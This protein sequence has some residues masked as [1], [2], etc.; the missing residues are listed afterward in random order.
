MSALPCNYDQP[1]SATERSCK[2]C[3]GE[4]QGEMLKGEFVADDA[5]EDGKG[6]IHESCVLPEIVSTLSP[7]QRFE[8]LRFV[9]ALRIIQDASRFTLEL[10]D[11]HPLANFELRELSDAVDAQ[12]VLLDPDPSPFPEEL[13]FVRASAVV[14]AKAALFGE[15]GRVKGE[16]FMLDAA[17]C[18]VAYG[19]KTDR[20][21]FIKKAANR[22]CEA[23]HE[24]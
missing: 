8:M 16:I 5:R 23:S 3:T 18:P 11:R 21:E 9:T 4:I 22:L 6:F 17:A 2:F 7:E 15:I 20:L 10:F 1:A 14:K 19:V 12:L 24:S 13:I